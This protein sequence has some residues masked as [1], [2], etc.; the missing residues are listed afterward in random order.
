MKDGVFDVLVAG[1]GPAGSTLSLLLARAG[2]SVALLERTCYDEFR[3]GESL[4]PGAVPRLIRLGIWDALLRTK[5]A[6]VH[7]VQSSWGT[8]NL[9]SSSFLAHPFLNGWHIDRSRFDSTLSA[10]AAKAGALVFSRTTVGSVQRDRQCTWSVEANSSQGRSRLSARFLVDACGR[11]GCLHKQLQTRRHDA[12]H[13]VGIA[14]AYGGESDGDVLP[15]LIEARPQGWW[16][17]AGLPSGSTIAIFFT[18]ADLCARE[19][20]AEPGVLRNLLY[21]SKYTR[22]RFE[23]RPF[24]TKVRVFPAGTHFLDRGAGDSWLAIGDA[25]IG[26]DPL[27][28]SGI[29]FALASAE[30]AYDLIHTMAVGGDDSAAIYSAEVRSDF[31]AYVSQRNSYYAMEDR[32]P[33]SPFWQRRQKVSLSNVHTPDFT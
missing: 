15:S 25:L 7:G 17:S 16:Y 22:E 9:E 31:E 21:E 18:D 5:P 27:S 2:C 10:E 33:D 1:G 24:P 26:R 4:P 19:S 30:R 12:D 3:V 29:D 6:A 20:L 13:L 23:Y 28:S 8:S 11:S 32:W 14:V